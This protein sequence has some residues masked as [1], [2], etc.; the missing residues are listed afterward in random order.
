MRLFRSFLFSIWFNVVS[1][2]LVMG[3][4]PIAAFAPRRMPAYAGVWGRSV[5]AGMPLFDCQV[6]IEGAENLPKSGKMLI[7]SQHQSAF[8]TMLWFRLVPHPRYIVKIELMRIPL[9]GILARLS[10]QIGVD[11]DA[12]AS[13]LREMLHEADRAWDEGAQI[14]IFPE[15]T[16]ADVGTVAK[17]HPGVAAL[18]R[19]SHLPVIPVT[20]DSGMCWG[21]GFWRKRPGTIRV[22]IHPALPAGLRREALMTQLQALFEAEAAA[23]R[24]VGPL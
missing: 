22:I 17:L 1:F 2:V 15:G 20:T 16:R 12:G 5:L 8:D 4:L 11:R 9:F 23:Q 14:V 24:S 7:A 6:V 18:A 19:H 3:G 10:R 13:A 21:K